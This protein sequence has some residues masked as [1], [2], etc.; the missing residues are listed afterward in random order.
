MDQHG[1]GAVAH[2][3]GREGGWVD[4]TGLLARHGQ[5]GVLFGFTARGGRAPFSFRRMVGGRR[6]RVGLEVGFARAAFQTGQFVAQLLVLG[7]E[8]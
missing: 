1:S 5:G 6:R 8:G 2:R 3:I 4:E 7:M